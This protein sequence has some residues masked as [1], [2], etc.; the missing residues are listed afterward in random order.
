MQFTFN[1]K[2]SSFTYINIS[3]IYN[4]IKKHSH[5]YIIHNLSLLLLAPLH[6]RYF[7]LFHNLF[8]LLIASTLRILVISLYI[9]SIFSL[10]KPTSTF[11]F[12]FLLSKYSTLLLDF[13][14]FLSL[15]TT[16]FQQSIYSCQILSQS[17]PKIPKTN[18]TVRF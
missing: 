15:E 10:K 2:K 5:Q 6:Y 11:I 1:H 17:I 9:L 12:L 18:S 16:L 8:N 7:F 14:L 4:L 3:T 13:S